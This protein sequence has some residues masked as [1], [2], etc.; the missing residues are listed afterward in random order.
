MEFDLSKLKV[1]SSPHI[2]SSETTTQIMLDVI[3]A[4]MPAFAVSIYRFGLYAAALVI[5]SVG[6]CVLFEHFYCKLMKKASTVKDLSA[7]VTGI[8]IAFCCPNTTPLWTVILGDAFAILIVKQLFGG[9]GKNFMNPALTARAFL[10]ASYPVLMTKF[11][12]DGVSGATPLN[13]LKNGILPE[14]TVSD[15]ALGMTEGCI[16][17]I[18]A[19]ALI[20]GGL[21][22]LYRRVISWRIPVCY[23]GIV[24][25]VTLIFP[26]GDIP[27]FTYMLESILSGGLLLGA[28]FMATDY[29]TSPVTPLGQIIFGLGCG[30]LNVFI[31]YFG[32]YP[33]GTSYAILIMNT[34]V[35]LIE[36]ITVPKKFGAPKKVKEEKK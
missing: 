21:Y 12:A 34:L 19:L 8:L 26:K 33:E 13:A 6:F 28:I 20:L 22:L 5:V 36:K 4:L 29:T 2:R 17:E 16:G 25:L 18:S 23:I 24:A 9:I 14:A 30:L 10:L 11:Y 3:I 27:G 15:M 32:S 35:F 7:V 1:T 31:R